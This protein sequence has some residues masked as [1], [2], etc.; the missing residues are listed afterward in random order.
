MTLVYKLFIGVILQRDLVG[1]L[2]LV[3]E[4]L[5]IWWE[6]M[7][8]ILPNIIAVTYY[9]C[10][11]PRATKVEYGHT[12]LPRC[13]LSCDTSPLKEPFSRPL[14][15]VFPLSMSEESNERPPS[16]EDGI[17]VQVFGEANQGGRKHMEDVV[18]LEMQKK[19]LGQLFMAV[20]D[21]HG[22]KEAAHFADKELW[23][24]IR[25]LE[26]FET[27]DSEAV[28]K[29]ITRGFRETH[30]KMWSVRGEFRI[31]SAVLFTHTSSLIQL[32][33]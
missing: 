5:E 24:T 19:G 26:G 8:D 11:V 31:T 7:A 4:V 2:H 14:R 10:A 30:N 13:Q 12:S 22:G 3:N 25:S 17:S 20:F 33:K 28:K 16:S 21:G 23:P 32:I 6:E 1:L 15:T 29:A 9:A 18:G 27:T